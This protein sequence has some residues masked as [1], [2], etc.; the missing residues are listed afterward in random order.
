MNTYQKK[1]FIFDL[2]GTLYLGDKAIPGATETLQWVRA[3]GA[4]VRF[5]TNNPRFSC[6]FY[7]DKLNDLG[8]P[9]KAEEIVTSAKFTAEYLKTNPKFGKIFVLGED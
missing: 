4:K 7:S 2:D 8:I 9:A 3:Q 1:A 6:E 5:V